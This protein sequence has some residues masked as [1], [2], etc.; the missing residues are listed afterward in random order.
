MGNPE[1]DSETSRFGNR[2]TAAAL[3]LK[4]EAQEPLPKPAASGGGKQK[5]ARHSQ[6]EVAWSKNSPFSFSPIS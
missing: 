2:E 4:Y 5:L 6:Q 3:G 1:K